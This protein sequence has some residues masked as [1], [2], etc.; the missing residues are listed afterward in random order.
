[1]NNEFKYIINKYSE[2]EST[3]NKIIVSAFINSNSIRVK[4][5]EL[6][7]SLLINN[8]SALY[9]SVSSL[10][11]K[12][13]FDDLIEAFELAI[14]N[15]E[16]IINGAVYTPNYIKKFIVEHSLS[17]I[18]KQY[19]LILTSDISC[20]CGAFLFTVSSILKAK[21]QKSFS[22]IFKENIFGLDISQSSIE[23]TIILLTLL[24]LTSGED[25]KKFD[26]NLYCANAL[27]FDWLKQDKKIKENNGFD[28]I[29]G[30]PPYVRAKNIDIKSKE[31]MSLWNVTK[32]GN[33]DLYIPFFEIGVKQLNK[34]GVL[35]YITVNSF[36]K[37]INARELR[38]FLQQNK[39]DLKII[40]FGHEKIF[41]NKSAYTCISFITKATSNSISYKKESSK[42]LVQNEL[43]NFNQILY[44]DL[45]YQ[46]GWL[47]ND[48]R[49]I[50]N[51]LKIESAG[52][53]LGSAYKIK[54]GIATLCNNI[55]IF[56]PLSETK[57]YYV[58]VQNGKQ[59]KIEKKICRDIIKP[60]ILKYEHEIE[61]VKEKLIYPYSNGI[62]SLSLINEKFFKTN[63]PKAY[64]YLLDNK[65]DLQ[66]R[67]KGNGNYGAWYAYGRT[68]A[69]SDKGF[70]LLFPYMAKKSH[71]VFTD[72][73]DLLIYCGYAIFSE[74][75][76]ELKLLKVILE[77]KVFEYYMTNTSKPYS[78]GYLSYA[79]N[80][81]KNFGICGLTSKDKS[82]LM[83]LK[84]K[85]LIN[86]FLIKKYDL[87][88]L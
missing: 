2:N 27:S 26:F 23:R 47:L 48:T 67:D 44:N 19:N 72:Q 65:K 55:Y 31:L 68:Q 3:F 66:K 28:L 15:N 78:S 85:N 49:I 5:N 43:K 59:Y 6:I 81:V 82:I 50:K 84:N 36:F 75:V 51:I 21:T 64:N 33:S 40:D 46:K 69:L 32:S 38:K 13:T 20:G 35:G 56:K 79:K 22:E 34:N 1:M 4:N 87:C 45:N 41:E 9:Q 16:K 76:E 42:S 37:S 52:K 17:R 86:E 60:N 70:K 12:L 83:N 73:K 53:S 58:L 71:F 29:V 10:S 57:D 7:K 80:Y 25:K 63:F 54:N 8:N 11:Y 74:S 24:A 18:N 14:P 30:N 88:N 39:Y 61:S 62:N 77:S